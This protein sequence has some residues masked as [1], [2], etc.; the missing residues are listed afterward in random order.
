[1]KKASM[2]KTVLALVALWA[3]AVCFSGQS[4]AH[5]WKAPAD[6]VDRPNPVPADDA[7]IQR[8][9][10]AF[11]QNCA[12]CHGQGARGDGPAAA[13]MKP[14]PADLVKRA[15]QHSDGDFHW[16]ISTGNGP[17]PGFEGR[18]SDNLIWDTINFI[19]SLK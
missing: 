14:G 6:A 4:F 3:F 18:L 13:A 2:A 9:R 10:E 11:S 12:V 19:N 7:S 15:E 16:K 5:E 1:M 17:M 8:G